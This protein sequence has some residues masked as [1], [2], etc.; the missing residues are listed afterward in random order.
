MISPRV[1]KTGITA[2]RTRNQGFVDRIVSRYKPSRRDFW[3]RFSLV[4]RE[5]MQP[6]AD[7]TVLQQLMLNVQLFFAAEKNENTAAPAAK[8]SYEKHSDYFYNKRILQQTAERIFVK[9]FNS[10]TMPTSRTGWQE[11]TRAA[12]R[13]TRFLHAVGVGITQSGTPETTCIEAT[14]AAALGVL[15]RAGEQKAVQWQ[16]LEAQ[17]TGLAFSGAP[18]ATVMGPRTDS[19]RPELQLTERTVLR[20]ETAGTAADKPLPGT[21]ITYGRESSPAFVAFPQTTANIF[22]PDILPGQTLHRYSD[23]GAA[24]HGQFP[25]RHSPS[26][27][28]TF[29]GIMNT[30]TLPAVLTSRGYPYPL[31]GLILRERDGILQ[32]EGPTGTVKPTA[33]LVYPA[34]AGWRPLPGQLSGTGLRILMT[35]ANRW[36]RTLS[37]ESAI[38][39]IPGTM[40]KTWSFAAQR[41]FMGA[42]LAGEMYQPV[43]PAEIYT[44]KDTRRQAHTGQTIYNLPRRQIGAIYEYTGRDMAL[45]PSTD[46]ELRWAAAKEQMRWQRIMTYIQ[47]F[48]LSG[49][50]PARTGRDK[51]DRHYAVPLLPGRVVSRREPEAIA[52]RMPLLRGGEAYGRETWQWSLTLP[53]IQTETPEATGQTAAT[54]DRSVGMPLPYKTLFYNRQHHL[55]ETGIIYEGLNKSLSDRIVNRIQTRLLTVN[56]HL[57]FMQPGCSAASEAIVPIGRSDVLFRSMTYDQPSAQGQPRYPR[58]QGVVAHEQIYNRMKTETLSDRIQRL[59]ITVLAT[60]GQAVSGRSAVAARAAMRGRFPTRTYMRLYRPV[61]VHPGKDEIRQLP[62]RQAVYKQ[63]RARAEQ[64][65]GAVYNTAAYKPYPVGKSGELRPVALQKWTQNQTTPADISFLSLKVLPASA[66]TNGEKPLARW[67]GPGSRWIKPL[68]HAMAQPYTNG[69]A[70]GMLQQLDVEP[71]RREAAPGFINIQVNSRGNAEQNRRQAGRV[72]GEKTVKQLQLLYATVPYP[73]QHP[74]ANL[75]AGG[76]YYSLAEK[77]VALTL[78][79]LTNQH[80]GIL[81]YRW[82]SKLAQPGSRTI[83][84]EKGQ[85][86]RAGTQ[87]VPYEKYHYS[88]SR[89][90]AAPQGQPDFSFSYPWP[91][92]QRRRSFAGDRAG[93]VFIAGRVVQHLKML[94]TGRKTGQTCRVTGADG[95]LLYSNNKTYA[96]QYVRQLREQIKASPPAGMP[97]GAAGLYPVMASS[98]LVITSHSAGAAERVPYA[99]DVTYSRQTGRQRL[100][101]Q[102]AGQGWL[103]RMKTETLSDR[104]QRL[105]ITVLAT[106]GQAVS[107]RSAVAARAAM[108][109][110][111]PT[112]TYMRL[113]R[114]V[115]VHPG[116]DEIRQLPSRQAVYKQPRARAEQ[117]LGAV[118]NTA[119]YKPYPVGKS[120]ELRP[121]ALQKW[122]QNQTTPADISFLSLKV[123]PASAATNG[124]KPLARWH[125]PG[126]RWIKPL[127][128]AMAQPYTNGIAEGMLQQLDVEPYRREAARRGQPDFSFSYPW[129]PEQGRRSFAGDRAGAVCADSR[130]VQRFKVLQ[131]GRKTGQARRVTGAGSELLYSNNETYAEQYVRQLREQAARLGLQVFAKMETLWSRMYRF[132]AALKEAGV[133]R[134]KEQIKAA[135]PAGM[136][137]GA[138]GVYPVMA[139]GQPVISRQMFLHYPGHPAGEDCGVS[140]KHHTQ[141]VISERVFAG[142]SRDVTKLC[143]PGQRG[144]YRQT[145]DMQLLRP[146]PMEQ[147][148][149][150]Q[151]QTGKSQ[152]IPL[153]KEAARRGAP[154]RLIQRNRLQLG[155]LQKEKGAGSLYSPTRLR[156]AAMRNITKVLKNIVTV[157]RET[158]MQ[159]KEHRQMPDAVGAWRHSISPRLELHNPRPA[160]EI[161]MPKPPA[162]KKPVQKEVNVGVRGTSRDGLSNNEI[163]RIA[164]KVYMELERKIKNE[165][166][167]R[168]L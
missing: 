9:N 118:Y 119:A 53:F 20:R 2:N 39:E 6:S 159:P 58:L 121:V 145:K 22:R 101:E 32:R 44:A 162:V 43:H 158:E 108:R 134:W 152:G 10:L 18:T 42:G 40:G 167:R 148:L 16:R 19:H 59:V 21:I 123:L 128:H 64:S 47:A 99:L 54:L 163:R 107:G 68:L 66:A 137:G 110:R 156:E 78:N 81:G 95:K 11:V 55:A 160:A 114:P 85:I 24:R 27:K 147:R 12:G 104:I 38:W 157:S 151:G 69:I 92:E 34:R 154:T 46:G 153:T 89:K 91:P 48:S 1:I 41:T 29:P 77:L 88:Y 52:V 36:V 113:Y 28:K 13:T 57:R 67:H 97:G 111:F 96:E 120:G 50:P 112:R 70:E 124:E 8:Y 3:K 76:W 33:T 146:A 98:Q 116:K 131:A 72:P 79:R 56:R 51:Q 26:G 7:S 65:L 35:L 135:P 87:E 75:T 73:Q 63:P 17:L 127:L 122:T 15:W 80:T 93:A 106:Y 25:Y 45:P 60:Y 103:L 168:G 23:G 161:S 149:W 31:T 74:I 132:G 5:N 109:G 86:F 105:V 61:S 142:I 100:R 130:I 136:P 84:R 144:I 140:V 150:P 117:S 143:F 37:C 126:S 138:E 4:F 125:G 166:Q 155:P 165:R 71:Y 14:P 102:A 49:I 141:A 133:S 90:W 129:L 115:S 139:P 164:D 30:G 94:Q 82:F 62:S 83:L